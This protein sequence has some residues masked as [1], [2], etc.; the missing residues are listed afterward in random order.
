MTDRSCAPYSSEKDHAHLEKKCGQSRRKS[1]QRGS[2]ALCIGKSPDRNGERPSFVSRE[3][4][5]AG[6]FS[7]SHSS[8]VSGLHNPSEI[9]WISEIS[10]SSAVKGNHPSTSVPL[11]NLARLSSRGDCKVPLKQTPQDLTQQAKVVIMCSVQFAADHS[12]VWEGLHTNVGRCI[13]LNDTF[14][15]CA[16]ASQG[17]NSSAQQQSNFKTKADIL[18]LC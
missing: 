7:S 14:Q 16:R 17:A 3:A 4:G 8:A 13:T 11:Q 9:T 1:L 6:I 12:C 5:T 10:A 2:S 18:S 15:N